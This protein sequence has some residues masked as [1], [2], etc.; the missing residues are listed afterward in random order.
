MK[1]VHPIFLVKLRCLAAGEL[2]NVSSSS[3]EY[4]PI[5]QLAN[6][7]YRH[8]RS[9]DVRHLEMAHGTSAVPKGNWDVLLSEV[10]NF[11]TFRCRIHK[12]PARLASESLTGIWGHMDRGHTDSA[13][14]ESMTTS[15]RVQPESSDFQAP[16]NGFSE[17]APLS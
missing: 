4:H 11:A 3:P 5:A 9:A 8:E 2:Q 1:N 16:H 17:D 7:P 14:P 10:C 15:T 12:T 6:A 13:A